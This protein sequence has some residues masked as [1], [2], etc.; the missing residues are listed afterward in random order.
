MGVYRVLLKSMFGENSCNSLRAR[1]IDNWG[2]QNATAR[3]VFVQPR[4]AF[5]NLAD[6][7]ILYNATKAVVPSQSCASRL[8]RKRRVDIKANR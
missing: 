5:R 8:I 1:P 2:P 6:W 3:A 7:G 4:T